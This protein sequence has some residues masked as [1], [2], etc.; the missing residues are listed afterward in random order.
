MTA[1]EA[2]TARIGDIPIQ[3]AERAVRAKSR[4]FFWYSPVLKDRLDHVTADA[5]VSPRTEAEVVQVLA[6]CYALD[7]P[8]TPRGG[9]TG[10][11][12][13]SMPIGGGIV[14]DMVALNRIK[15]VEGGRLT[16]E[17][18]ALMGDIEEYTRAEH[19]LEFRMHPSTRE[20]A[21]IGGFISG[22]S[23]GI[24][25]IRWGML[26][27]P[28]NILRVR[29]AT[30]EAEPRLIDLTGPEIAKVHHAYGLTG[31]ITELEVPL[32]PAQDWV[33]L[34]VA[35]DSWEAALNAGW[36]LAGQEGLWLK[37]LAAIEAPAP[38]RYFKRHA[39]FLE[40]GDHILA[41]LVAP[42]SLNPLIGV[43]EAAGGRIAFNSA[44]ASTEDKKGLP[45]LHH[46]CWNHTTLR[47]LKMEPEI[48]YLQIGFPEG[49]LVETCL[50]IARRYPDEITN[51]VEFTRAAGHKRASALP[52]VRFSDKARL[53][54]LIA[55]LDAMGCKNW[56]PHAYTFEEGNYTGAAGHLAELKRAHDPK[57]LLNPGKLIAWHEPDYAY[58]PKGNWAYPGLMAPAAE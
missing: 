9:G 6:A 17:P 44:S 45:H 46:L 29:M 11:Y 31:V 57:G 55:E 54:A 20:T 48:T 27:D 49:A 38:H 36:D 10:N 13:Q 21:T 34:L 4:D 33:E 25:S 58:D 30:M 2:L 8:V 14:L 42:N 7:I 41:I 15:S 12:G 37:Q 50:E 5:V 3:T 53:D 56:N 1:I 35:F 26:A 23:G 39:K 18:G 24:G 28:G 16:V 32:A 19:G 43:A 40:E 52:M 47:A 51:H 22:G